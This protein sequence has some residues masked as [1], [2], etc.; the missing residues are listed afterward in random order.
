MRDLV[1]VGCDIFTVGQY[2]RPSLLHHEVIRFWTPEEFQD[3]EK[4]GLEMGLGTVVAGPLVRSSYHADEAARQHGV[5]R[6][7]EV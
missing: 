7:L 1:E 4:K 2:L 5:A 6:S 3:L